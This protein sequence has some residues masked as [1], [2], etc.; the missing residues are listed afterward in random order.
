MLTISQVSKYFQTSLKSLLWSSKRYYFSTTILILFSTHSLADI[1]IQT[2]DSWNIESY[3]AD[4][5]MVRKLSEKT[6]SYLAFEMSRPFCICEDLAFVRYESNE[7]KKNQE[8]EGQLVFNLMRPKKVT[9]VVKVADHDWYVLG[10]KQFPTIRD[11]DILDIKSEYFKDRY[12]IRGLD[13]VMAQSKTMC[14]SFIEYQQVK[15]KEID[16]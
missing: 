5:L 10:I 12:D 6:D 15:A 9:F 13:H 4:N 8:F 3:T 16:V 2:L 14:E 1:R 11:A 7:F